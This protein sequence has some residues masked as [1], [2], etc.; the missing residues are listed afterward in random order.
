MR[1]LPAAAFVLVLFV[2]GPLTGCAAYR[3]CGLHGC[4]GD[5]DIT[6]SVRALFRQ[7]AVLEAPTLINVQT[8]NHVVYLYG[9]VDTDLQRRLA[10]SI[11][12]TVPGVVKVV[13]AI[14]LTNISG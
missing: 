12:L 7:H 11:A 14:G 1:H 13:N 3:E 2:V 8:L 6:S 4:A 10:E 9:M 5:L